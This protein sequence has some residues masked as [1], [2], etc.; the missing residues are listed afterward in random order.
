MYI[1]QIPLSPK[2][3]GQIADYWRIRGETLK[4]IECYRTA[5]HINP[6]NSD[7][8]LS[9]ARLFYNYRLFED[10]VFL[11]RKSLHVIEDEANAWRQYYLL[12]E[13]YG[14]IK[15]FDDSAAF[16]KK[17][18]ELNPGMGTETCL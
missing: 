14:Q 3:L 1:F 13:T 15:Q 6:D 9:L 8:L 12:A 4:A 5:L 7:I 11:T 10:V 18:L 2:L 16:Y 17:T